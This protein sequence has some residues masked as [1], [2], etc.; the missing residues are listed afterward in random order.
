MIQ[1]QKGHNDHWKSSKKNLLYFYTLKMLT[2][3]LLSVL[4]KLD[5]LYIDTPSGSAGDSGV[6]REPA[7]ELRWFPHCTSVILALN[8]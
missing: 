5:F 7:Q 6:M 8:K 2:I 4:S 3:K 1:H